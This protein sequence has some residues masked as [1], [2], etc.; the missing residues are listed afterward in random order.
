MRSPQLNPIGLG[1]NTIN[2]NRERSVSHLLN[3]RQLGRSR[4][5][6][7]YVGGGKQPSQSLARAL[8]TAA[9]LHVYKHE[10]AWMAVRSST[11]SGSG[12]EKTRLSSLLRYNPTWVNRDISTLAISLCSTFHPEIYPPHPLPTP[13]QYIQPQR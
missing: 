5:N 11:N 1:T 2:S 6:R 12:P 4:S 7:A 3:Q 13:Y 9:H 10:S 8:Y